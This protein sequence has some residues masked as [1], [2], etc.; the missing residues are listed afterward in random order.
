MPTAVRDVMTTDVVA[1]GADTPFKAA[2]RLVVDHRVSAL[3]VL[4]ADRRVV[5]VVS[6]ADLLHKQE[7]REQGYREDYRPTFR[8]WL[9][10]RLAARGSARGKAAGVRVA[11]VMSAPAITVSPDA[12]AVAAARHLER[13]D[14]RRLPVVDADGHLLGIV[15][16]GDLLRVFDQDDEELRRII[17]AEL[18]RRTVWLDPGR[19]EVGVS[20]GVVTL[21]GHLERRYDCDVLERA[22]RRVDG[23]VDV[24]TE[25]TWRVDDTDPRRVA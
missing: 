20:D 22:I 4:D 18:D 12:S 8:T 9:R 19:I 24:R 16:R 15:T 1:V 11:D 7:Y 10:R 21:V 2:A 3:P 5:G 17:R 14:V 23:V 6:E 25:L 13:H